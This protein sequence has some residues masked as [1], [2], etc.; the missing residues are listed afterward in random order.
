MNSE[1]NT[2]LVRSAAA[3]LVAG[4]CALASS[5]GSVGAQDIGTLESRIASARTDAQGLAADIEAKTAALAEARS[6]AA[7]AAQREAELAGVLARGRERAAALA[8]RVSEAEARLAETRE[9]LRAAVAVLE[10]RLVAIYTSEMPDAT[11][12]L[13]DSDG[14]EDLITRADYLH[15]IEDADANLVARVR[16]LREQV[17][18]ELAAVREAHARQEAFNERV[19]TAHAEIAAARADA[20]AEAA[21]LADARAAQANALSG[22]RSQVDDWTAEVQELQEVS[23]IQA[24]QVVGEW[25]GDWAIPSSIVMCESG[26]NFGALNPSS[27][28]GG[29][30]QILPSTWDTYGGEGRPNEASPGEQHQIAEQIWADS[31]SSAWACAG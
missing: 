9:R 22:L 25:V 17:E 7:A 27:G 8:E 4:L 6:Q 21:A 29:A 19:E 13:L 1:T 23:E 24:Q 10:E 20:E 2:R 30:Y 26:G 15:Q 11:T 12:L 28:A 5:T 3:A 16:M 18:R 14:Y 31:G